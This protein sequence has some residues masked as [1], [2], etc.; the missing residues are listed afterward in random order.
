MKITK[1]DRKLIRGPGGRIASNKHIESVKRSAKRAGLTLKEA[2]AR[3]IKRN[4]LDEKYAP[5]LRE[6]GTKQLI[7]R[8]AE[9]EILKASKALNIPIEQ[10]TSIFFEGRLK[11]VNLGNTPLHSLSSNIEAVA[12]RTKKQVFKIK[13]PGEK[14]FRRFTDVNRAIKLIEEQKR[15]IF[16]QIRAESGKTVIS[17]EE[18]PLIPV[19]EKFSPGQFLPE[20]TKIDFTKI[21]SMSDLDD[22][23]RDEIMETITQGNPRKNATKGKTKNKRKGN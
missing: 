14:R 13:L 20:E 8:E 9:R 4:K 5:R 18:I 21:M 22:D 23:E 6:P 11:R 12:D 16:E 1:R 3:Y 10:A 17:S 7:S 2:N 15:I 19:F